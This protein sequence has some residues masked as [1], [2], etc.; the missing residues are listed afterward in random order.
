MHGDLV[1]GNVRWSP[2]GAVT[3][4]IDLERARVTDPGEDLVRN[5]W[6]SC[7]GGQPACGEAFVG[8]YGLT[9]D[10]ARRMRAYLV[11]DLLDVWEGGRARRQAWFGDVGT[12]GEWAAP[13]CDRVDHI[14]TTAT[15]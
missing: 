6:W 5:L 2:D 15:P 8:R 1:I 9:A 4:V 13:L 3:G 12:F 7:Y 10:L 11:A 14:I